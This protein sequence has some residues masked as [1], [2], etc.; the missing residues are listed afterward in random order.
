MASKQAKPA[1]FYAGAALVL[2]DL[3]RA[4]DQPSMAVDIMR[5]NGIT[6]ELLQ[7]DGTVPEDL[8]VIRKA[9][10]DAGAVF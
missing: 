3:I 2:A 7:K 1:G 5:H 8:K 9:L 10:S 6:L 4:N